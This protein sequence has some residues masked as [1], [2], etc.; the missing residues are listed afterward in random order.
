MSTAVIAPRVAY[1]TGGARTRKEIDQYLPAN[2]ATVIAEAYPI[3]GPMVEDDGSYV[4]VAIVGIDVAGW[5]LDDYVIPRLA[6]GL[7][8]AEEVKSWGSY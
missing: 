6:S 8:F 3:G 4:R 5:T 7:I 2:Y 1:V